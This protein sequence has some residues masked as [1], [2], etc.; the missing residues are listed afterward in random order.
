MAGILK[1]FGDI[2]SSNINALLDKMEN[3]EKMMNQY[4]RNMENDL[5]Q[6]KAETASVMA[7]ESSAKRKLDACEADVQKLENYAIMA[8]KNG[9]DADAKQFLAQKQKK[10]SEADLLRQDYQIAADNAQKMQQMYKKLNEDIA[11]LQQR[12]RELDTKMS[13]AK[14]REKANKIGGSVRNA[15][16]TL[17]DFGKMEEKINRRLDEADAMARLDESMQENSLDDLMSK[18]DSQPS[19]GVEDELAALKA[20]MGASEDTSAAAG[21]AGSDGLD[22]ELAALKAKLGENYT[23]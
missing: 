11:T 21:P 19:S 10:A 9:N 7:A 17:S 2:M 12:K 13:I 5:A 20:R 16:G 8:V 6:V 22:D 18:Y 1:R 4:L 15:Q 23:G 3:P 14:S